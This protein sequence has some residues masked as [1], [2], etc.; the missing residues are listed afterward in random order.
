MVESL[1]MIRRKGKL[2]DVDAEFFWGDPAEIKAQLREEDLRAHL[3]Q[4]LAER[5]L[6]ALAM[7]TRAQDRGG[8]R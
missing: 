6:A 3:A 8:R 5:L 4:P 7:V 1:A 2:G